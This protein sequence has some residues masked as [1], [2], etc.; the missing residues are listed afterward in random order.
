VRSTTR[1]SSIGPRAVDALVDHDLLAVEADEVA[2]G[3]QELAAAE[4]QPTSTRAPSTMA[5]RAA[6]DA[7]RPRGSSSSR[8]AGAGCCAPGQPS[9][10]AELAGPV[11]VVVGPGARSRWSRRGP[12]LAGV[13]VLV[14][15]QHTVMLSGPPPALAARSAARPPRRVVAVA[16][17]FGDVVV[18]D[19]AGQPVGAQQ[20]LVAGLA[21]R[22]TSSR[23]RPRATP[24]SRG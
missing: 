13:R 17:S 3:E 23:R 21:A 24:R 9:R 16:S 20:Q 2:A 5:P 18:V 11:A 4:D 19:D 10:S 14:A 1:D 22:G 15:Q 7:S 12:P 6:E 8:L